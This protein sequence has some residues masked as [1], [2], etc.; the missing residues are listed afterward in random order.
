[1]CPKL[2]GLELNRTK[3]I[4]I[5]SLPV[6]FSLGP[7]YPPETLFLANSPNDQSF[8]IVKSYIYSPVHS[9]KQG[10]AGYLYMAFFLKLST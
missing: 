5:S 1:M 6:Q 4:Q 2:I 3:R 8:S 10:Q 7:K 9:N